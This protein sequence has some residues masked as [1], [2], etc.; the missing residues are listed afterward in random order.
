MFYYIN[1]H[2]LAHYIQIITT[3][4]G[5]GVPSSGKE[6]IMNC[7]LWFV[8]YCILLSALF[9]NILNQLQ[10]VHDCL[11]VCL[12]VCLP[13]CLSTLMLAR[14]LAHIIVIYSIILKP[15]CEEQKFAT[16]H[17]S[18]YFCRPANVLSV[19][20]SFNPQFTGTKPEFVSLR[21]WEMRVRF[22]TARFTTGVEEPFSS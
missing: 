12:S 10:S 5:T 16:S 19:L 21:L 7:V 6:L 20:P 4:F 9:V 18:L 3:C 11:S 2:L 13:A 8:L 15:R 22:T 14:C 17:R 1:V